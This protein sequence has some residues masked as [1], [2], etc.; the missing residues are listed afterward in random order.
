MRNKTR[1]L[2]IV[3]IIIGISFFIMNISYSASSLEPQFVM[4]RCL[5]EKE[6]NFSV[7][8]DEKEDYVVFLPGFVELQDLT[9]HLNTDSSI[10]INDIL[11]KEGLCCDIFEI[12]QNYEVV[13]QQ[14]G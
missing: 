13:F 12:D 1:I 2:L 11:L 5:E 6:I 10:Y 9:I 14:F 8:E 4:K 3:T 7:W